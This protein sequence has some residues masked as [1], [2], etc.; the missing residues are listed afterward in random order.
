MSAIFRPFSSLACA[1]RGVLAA[2]LALAVC[3]LPARAEVA[4]SVAEASNSSGGAGAPEDVQYQKLIDAA[5]A[6]VQLKVKAL[7]NARSNESL[8]QERTGSGVLIGNDGLILTAGYLVL[9]ADDVQVVDAKGQTVP[10]RVVAYDNA[11]GFGLLRPLGP[12]S[13]KAIPIGSAQSISQLDRLMIIS[14]G[15]SQ[16]ISIA[17]VV[18]KRPFA[19]YWEYMIDDAIFTAPARLDHSGAAL[20]N[21]DGELVGIGSLFVMDALQ[22]GQRLP[23]N[24]FLPV[25]L[26]KPILQEL[27]RDGSQPASHRPWLG[28]DSLEEDGR[29]KVMQVN[30]ESPAAQAGI[31]AGDIILSVDGQQV[32]SLPQFYQHVWTSGPAGVDVPLT[33]LHGAALKTIVVRSIDRQQF[34]RHKPAV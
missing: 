10:A 19:G 32:D 7:P 16:T 9:E 31:Q 34:I 28:I 23:G 13:A 11:S 30:E 6:V 1:S 29:I 33:V 15:E 25:D 26:L 14:G 5:N 12:I 8:G 3:A 21:K 20:V 27:V 22:P 18:S 17:T 24:M 4:A 2:V